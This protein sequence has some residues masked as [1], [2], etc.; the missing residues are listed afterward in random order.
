MGSEREL[1]RVSGEVWKAGFKGL[2]LRLEVREVGCSETRVLSREV[3]QLSGTASLMT[4]VETDVLRDRFSLVPFLCLAVPT[5]FL[6]SS[7][8]FPSASTGTAFLAAFCPLAG[9]TRSTGLLLGAG[10]WF[11]GLRTEVRLGRTRER[12]ALG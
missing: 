8:F 12:L 3:L 11:L 5:T 2:G 6:P 10:V 9:S 1:N 7:T 4:E